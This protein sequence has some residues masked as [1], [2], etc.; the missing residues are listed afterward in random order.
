MQ[1]REL[2]DYISKRGW[3]PADEYVDTG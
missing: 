1:L 2:R 3:E